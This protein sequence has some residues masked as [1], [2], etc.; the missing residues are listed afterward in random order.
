MN[1]I[2]NKNTK[3][4][5]KKRRDPIVRVGLDPKAGRTA[6]RRIQ[7]LKIKLFILPRKT[8]L[9]SVTCSNTGNHDKRT[10]NSKNR[11]LNIHK[12]PITRHGTAGVGGELE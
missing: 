3:I 10:K 8:H 5:F 7:E 1:L 2:Q 9:T 4:L 6:T 11:Q 12:E